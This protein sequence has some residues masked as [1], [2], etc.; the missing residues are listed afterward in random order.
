MSVDFE[1]DALLIR[2]TLGLK[3][4]EGSVDDKIEE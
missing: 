3:G 2:D 4:G 1:K